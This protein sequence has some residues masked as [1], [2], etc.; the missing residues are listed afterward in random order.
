MT[1]SRSD[2]VSNEY[3]KFWEQKGKQQMDRWTDGWRLLKLDPK[4]LGAFATHIKI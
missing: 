1:I 4:F 2:M 3:D